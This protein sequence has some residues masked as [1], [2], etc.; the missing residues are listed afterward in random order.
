MIGRN[1]DDMKPKNNKF[2]DMNPPI[3][4]NAFCIEKQFI[5]VCDIY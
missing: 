3:Y 1:L 4:D 2:N 5:S